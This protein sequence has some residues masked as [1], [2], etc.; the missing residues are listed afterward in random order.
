MMNVVH[1]SENGL[2]VQYISDFIEK[3]HADRY[4]A[5]LRTLP[6]YT[7]TLRIRGKEVKPKRLQLAYGDVNTNYSYSGTN[8]S[9]NPWTPLMIELRDKVEKQMACTFNYVLLNCYVDGSNYISQHKDNESSLDATFPITVISFGCKRKIEF[10]RPNVP[11]TFIDLEHG[12]LYSMGKHTNELFTHG[13]APDPT[14]KDMRIS[15]TFRHM[16][17]HPL[18]LKKPKLNLDFSALVDDPKLKLDLFSVSPLRTE[19]RDSTTLTSSKQ[20]SALN[21]PEADVSH[22][23]WFTKLFPDVDVYIP[24]TWDLGWNTYVKVVMENNCSLKVDIRNYKE[25]AGGELF[26][27]KNGVILMAPTFDH[28]QNSISKFNF[29]S[30][31][32][33]TVCN[34]Q[35]LMA[36]LDENYCLLQ[37]IFKTNNN[38][39][40]HFKPSALR[41]SK[42][43]FI[44][45]YDFCS[46]ISDCL[47]DTI[48][49]K[50]IP[51]SILNKVNICNH[52][53]TNIDTAKKNFLS[54]FNHEIERSLYRVFNC[55]SCAIGQ[56][57]QLDHECMASNLREKFLLYKDSALLN[58][59]VFQFVKNLLQNH[60]TCFYTHSFFDDFNSDFYESYLETV[61]VNDCKNS[62]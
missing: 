16:I 18:D 55:Y 12:S 52:S 34:N 15:L 10:K 60:C 19:T 7:P 59:N 54:C 6:F 33:T 42:D 9:A 62:V 26:P 5:E 13:I 8:V 61:F 35:L 51:I 27:T 40:F 2:N 57:S 14:I 31:K 49:T 38:S 50:I 29:F 23:N 53:H 41:L 43:Q 22:N 46:E 32:D 44:K 47:I 1:F 4:F 37:Q 28:F 45:L 24:E 25:L 56:L 11:S 3:V 30:V 39:G 36:F 20:I 21:R 48:L 17:S 58:F